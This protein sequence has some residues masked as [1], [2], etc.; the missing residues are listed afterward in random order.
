LERLYK[1]ARESLVVGAMPEKGWRVNVEEVGDWVDE[2][3]K[4]QEKKV[5]YLEEL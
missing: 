5:N 3:G 1:E 4:K 2:K